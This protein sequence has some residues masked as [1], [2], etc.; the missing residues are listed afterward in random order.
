MMGIKKKQRSGMNSSLKK[1]SVT[2]YSPWF[3]ANHPNKTF[4]SSEK[5]S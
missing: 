4:G 1:K 2:Y 5:P 3:M